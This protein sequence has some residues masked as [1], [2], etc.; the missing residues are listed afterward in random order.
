MRINVKKF[1]AK[2]SAIAF[3]WTITTE[4]FEFYIQNLEFLWDIQKEA[5][6]CRIQI[7][8]AENVEFELVN[9]CVL[10]V[11]AENIKT[12]KLWDGWNPDFPKGLAKTVTVK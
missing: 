7:V 9:K 5:L 2:F 1:S 11:K 10:I 3:Q 8:T 4:E 6:K 12:E